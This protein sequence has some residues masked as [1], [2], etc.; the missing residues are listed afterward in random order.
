MTSATVAPLEDTYSPPDN[1]SECIVSIS[2][3]RMLEL[4][5]FKLSKSMLK[6]LENARGF[7]ECKQKLD[8]A[9]MEVLPE[10]YMDQFP[11][12][13]AKL[14][15]NGVSTLQEVRQAGEAVM[16]SFEEKMRG[17]VKKAGLDPDEFAFHNNAKLPIDSE[18]D[19]KVLTMAP[20]KSVARCSEKIKNEYGG[21]ASKI[22]DVVRC[23]IVVN[24]EEELVTVAQNLET[25]EVVRLKNRFS[26]PLFNGESVFSVAYCVAEVTRSNLFFIFFHQRRVQRWAL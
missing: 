18:H 7:L 21:D 15:Q 26:E 6:L 16:V 5:H 20:L 9:A 25:L 19:F 17:I 10:L 11:S 1:Q 13:K 8:K 2:E 23:S 24:R 14:E 12:R 22:V 4:K 3:E